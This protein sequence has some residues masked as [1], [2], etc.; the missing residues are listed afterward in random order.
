MICDDTPPMGGF[1]GGFMSKLIFTNLNKLG[2][3]QKLMI[4][5]FQIYSFY[6][7]MG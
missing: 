7:E 3:I 5:W 4:H 1:M 2:I 6:K